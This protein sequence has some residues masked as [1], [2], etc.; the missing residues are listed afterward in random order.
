MSKKKPCD[1]IISEHSVSDISLDPDNNT[2]YFAL[3]SDSERIKA[4]AEIGQPYRLYQYRIIRI[5]S[6][7]AVYS[8]NLIEYQLKIKEIL[9]IPAKSIIEVKECS[10][11]FA[12]EVI[13]VK[14][15]PASSMIRMEHLPQKVIH[16]TLSQYTEERI[17]HYFTLFRLLISTPESSDITMTLL[18]CA[19]C[20]DMVREHQIQ[21]NQYAHIS[22]DNNII[23]DFIE[24]LNQYGTKER[25]VSFYSDKLNITP[26]YL[27]AIVKRS[28]GMTVMNWVNKV[29]VM[30]AK[31]LLGNSTMKIQDIAKL[32]NFPES[33]VF[34]RY[35]RHYT[36]QTPLTYRRNVI[37]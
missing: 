36:G 1:I 37:N 11:N 10:E 14:S 6:G 18:T 5:L 21:R 27:N 7:F 19:L 9:I 20:D 25:N 17:E 23:R 34:I 35:F 31:V 4:K 15:L 30:E 3:V 29:T 13:I 2:E 32:L 26:N 33:T 16:V 24:I 12:V 22:N 8:I 28:T